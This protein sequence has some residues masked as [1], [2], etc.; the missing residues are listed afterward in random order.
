MNNVGMLVGP[1]RTTV[2]TGDVFTITHL[3]P[4]ELGVENTLSQNILTAS[5]LGVY[6]CRITSSEWRDER[7]QCWNIS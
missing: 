1:D 3:R 6:T 4:G 2:T 5:H 7:Y